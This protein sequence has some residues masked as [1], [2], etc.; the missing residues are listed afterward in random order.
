[1]WVGLL[2]ELIWH[3]SLFLFRYSRPFSFCPLIVVLFVEPACNGCIIGCHCQCTNTTTLCTGTWLRLVKLSRPSA[4]VCNVSQSRWTWNIAYLACIC[5]CSVQ[6]YQLLDEF[7]A[8]TKTHTFV[9]E[10]QLQDLGFPINIKICVAP[11]LNQTALKDLGY[12]NRHD[13]ITGMSK[14]KKTLVGWGGHT[15]HTNESSS[16]LI[17]SA[18]QALDTVRIDG[19]NYLR[20][21]EVATDLGDAFRYN[22][23]Q[24]NLT[25]KTCGY[26]NVFCETQSHT[27]Q[28]P[29]TE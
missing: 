26:Q 28:C 20:H 1:M 16:A 13:Y 29:L 8:P 12:K 5:F 2:P 27:V 4:M 15:S 21:V 22:P 17:R 19:I 3:T 24:L 14:F 25:R 9:E 6:L 10:T 18:K 23:N 11:S 7:F